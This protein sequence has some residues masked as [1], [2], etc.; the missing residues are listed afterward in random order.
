MRVIPVPEFVVYAAATVALAT[1]GAWSF[2]RLK[3][4]LN[5]EGPIA[6]TLYMLSHFVIFGT[7]YLL[8]EDITYGWLVINIW[9]NAQY[10]L[11]VWLF[12]TNKFKEGEST[13]ARLLSKLSQPQNRIW[14]F[15]FCIALS[16][17][18]YASISVSISAAFAEV[19]GTIGPGDLFGHQLP[20]L[21]WSTATS[22]K[23][24][25]HQSRKRWKLKRVPH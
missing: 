7:G 5:G 21:H 20:P 17:V 11:F 9:H 24:A 22:G 18:I 25:S 8:I 3:A 1:F 10:V 2:L 16:T 6:H 12:N 15:G 19:A 14:Y 4:F 13:K 23:C